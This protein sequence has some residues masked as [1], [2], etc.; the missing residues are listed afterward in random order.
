MT[1]WIGPQV[2]TEG[3]DDEALSVVIAEIQADIRE[4][5]ETGIVP[6]RPARS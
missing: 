5:V 4:F 1:V 2:E 3:L 6:D